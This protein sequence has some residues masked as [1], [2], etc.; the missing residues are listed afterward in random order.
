M[1]ERRGG[2]DSQQLQ[3]RGGKPAISLVERAQREGLSEEQLTREIRKTW[4]SRHTGDLCDVLEEINGLLDAGLISSNTFQQLYMESSSQ[5]KRQ[6]AST[7][8]GR[9]SRPDSRTQRKAARTIQRNWRSWR[10]WLRIRRFRA[11]VKEIDACIK[12]QSLLRGC[13]ERRIIA[14]IKAIRK[15]RLEKAAA[16][17]IQRAW[18]WWWGRE[19]GRRVRA[20]M[21]QER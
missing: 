6:G 9:R 3:K 14:K 2:G 5:Q 8:N 7:A 21:I 16:V 1:S 19:E 13:I 10:A 20:E 15:R 11:T 18:R 12:I 4:E 17:T